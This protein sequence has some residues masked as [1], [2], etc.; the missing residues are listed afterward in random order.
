M[1]GSAADRTTQLERASG[2]F[3]GR[4]AAMAS[5][6]EVLV[7]TDSEHEA[8][9]VLAAVA[10]CAWRIED[11]YSRYRSDNV[12]HAINDSRGA[13]VDVDPETADLLDFSAR[14]YALS[15]GLFDVTSGVLRRAWTFDGGSHVPDPALLAEL[16]QLVGWHRVSWQR[17]TLRLLPGMQL[18][19]GG[20]GKEYA[21]DQ[22][23]GIA[24]TLTSGSCLV[25]FGG[26]LV[27]NR[28]RRDG[29]SW[30]VGVQSPGGTADSAMTVI[31][32]KTGALATSG[33]TYR[34]ITHDGRRLGHVLDPRTGWPVEQ[35][36]RCVTVAAGTC[37]L[38]GM[39]TTLAILKG[40]RAEEFLLAEGLR[41][42][43]QR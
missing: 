1:A 13:P 20:F 6:C 21:V 26:D 41:H 22:A 31:E 15:G 28:P 12:V 38:A 37:T 34:F 40:D 8:A 18:D 11:K 9:T 23:A 14:L 10:N 39:F 42:W 24:G 30:Q 17:P 29:Q 16:L 36:P 32:L 27:V 43:I 3:A 35:A 19:F 25:N 4:F 5:P 2:H 33:D 7:E